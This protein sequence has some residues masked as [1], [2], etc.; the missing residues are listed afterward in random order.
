MNTRVVVHAFI[1]LVFLVPIMTMKVAVVTGANNHE[2]P[3]GRRLSRYPGLPQPYAGCRGSK[4]VWSKS[5]V[6]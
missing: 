1:S 2:R 3:L 6:Y 5:R 4:A